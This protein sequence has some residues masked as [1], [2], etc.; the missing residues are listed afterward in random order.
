MSSMP[1]VV[2]ITFAPAAKIFWILSFVMS[3]S[4]NQQ[5]VI[6]INHKDEL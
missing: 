2:K 5:N 1:P 4:L 6:Q 3:D